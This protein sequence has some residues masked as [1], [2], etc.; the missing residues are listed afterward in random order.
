MKPA[1]HTLIFV[2]LT[3]LFI[4]CSSDADEDCV[5]GP[6]QL[7]NAIA[8][9]DGAQ[10]QA[11]LL[12]CREPRIQNFRASNLLGDIVIGSQGTTI[13][14]NPQSF[15]QNGIFIDG[16]VDV[17]LIEMYQPGEIIAC[18]LSTNGINLSGRTE[19]LFSESIFYLNITYEGAPVTFLQPLR[20][21]APS[22]NLGMQQFLF[23]SPSCPQLEC[24]V[25][26]EE[27]ISTVPV[28]EEPIKGPNGVFITGYQAL[29]Q[30][31]GW[32][33]IGRYNED[34]NART[35]VYN[36]APTGYNAT[37]GNVFICYDTTS[38]AIG[39]FTEYDSDL[40]VFTEQFAQIPTGI[41]TNVIF[42]TVQNNQ[43]LYGTTDGIVEPEFLT[44]TLTTAQT[45]EQG[46]INALNNL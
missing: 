41:G 39:L 27:T 30:D 21:F 18:Q 14:V 31:V 37:N 2:L 20:V 42:V 38:T 13:F 22:S 16:E 4:G 46:M 17:Q 7:P 45:D 40:E 5:K 12:E 43:Y 19:P 44:A 11:S 28:F 8:I 9:I 6:L 32:K 15:E 35:T 1:N 26:W 36:K 23:D 34:G 24:K 25:L 33:S 3:F 10:Y 29:V